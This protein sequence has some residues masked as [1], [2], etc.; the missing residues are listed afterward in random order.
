MK[1][2][3]FI[4]RHRIIFLLTI[5]VCFAIDGFSQK[6]K[7]SFGLFAGYEFA[8]AYYETRKDIPMDERIK[9]N[10]RVGLVVERFVDTALVNI[11][12]GIFYQY[13][14]FD[15]ILR[16]DE[17]DPSYTN[18]LSAIKPEYYIVGIP[19]SLNWNI[20][21]K[22]KIY[23]RARTGLSFEISVF[24]KEVSEYYNGET[25]T[26]YSLIADGNDWQLGVPLVLGLGVDV[27]ISNKIRMGIYP[28]MNLYFKH[29]NATAESGGASTFGIN[30][31][32]FLK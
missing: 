28:M 27:D 6:Q 14:S 11:S 25:K 32:F 2:L 21:S 1:Q 5:L 10:Y 3:K 8:S 26:R 13:R 18:Y 9:A 17:L 12:Y 31:F 4:N 7:L 19:L 16:V 15:V 22:S 29:F 20:L 24:R 23:F 30:L